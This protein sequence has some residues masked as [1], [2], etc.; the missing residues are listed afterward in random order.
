M[1]YSEH[2]PPRFHVEYAGHKALVDIQ[3]ACVIGGTLPSRQLKL[4]LAWCELHRDELM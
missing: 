1:Y 4:I 3:S 2:N